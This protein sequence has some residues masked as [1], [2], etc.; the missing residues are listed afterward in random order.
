M[1]R[2]LG[3]TEV[4][5]RTRL[6]QKGGI[7][8]NLRKL[9]APS[10]SNY[11]K[12][13]PHLSHLALHDNLVEVLR[14]TVQRL[15]GQGLPLRVLE[16]GAGHGGFT[17]HALAMGCNVTVVDMSGPSVDE[18][19]RRFGTNPKFDSVY[20][21]D[22][23]LRDV[24]G[25]YTLLML[26]S[27]IHH[28]PDYISFLRD[29]SR[30]ISPGG[31][32]LTLQD[33]VWYPRHRASHEADRMS[34]FAWR[35]AQGN[36]IGGLKTRLRRIRG[37]LDET[38]PSDM[39]EYHVVRNG[40]DEQMVLSF[41]REEFSEATLIPY[42]SSHL[43]V[44]QHVGDRLGL[45]SAFGVVAH[46][47]DPGQADRELADR[48]LAGDRPA[49]QEDMLA[50]RDALVGDVKQQD[51][52]AVEVAD[53]ELIRRFVVVAEELNFTRAA[54]RL[55]LAQ[56]P[57]SA[58]I[59]KLERKLGVRL[60]ERTS[61][62]V[63]LT[64]AGAV[65]LEQGRITVE[66]AG[67]AIEQARRA[68]TQPRRLTVAVKPGTGTDLLKQIMQRC[69]EDPRMPQVHVLFGHPGG[70]AAAVRAGAADVAILRAPF[71]QRGLD[72]EL[73]LTE[74]RVAVLPAGHRLSGRPELRRAD[75]A[76]E[77][78][79]HWAGPPDPVA[80]AYWAGADTPGRAADPRD[81]ALPPGPEINDIS[82]LLDAVTL[83]HAVAYVPASV[84][85][86]HHA[87]DLAFI[88][89]SD[90]SPS[91]VMAAWP[92][93]SRSRAVAG[94]VRAAAEVAAAQA[95]QAAALA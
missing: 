61:R 69:A 21:P 72:A 74:P 5:S 57:L 45:N 55:G 62:R 77:P 83:G 94:F 79:P 29:A 9:H 54:A 50:A 16:I 64:P 3:K 84:A 63:T 91:Q 56:P 6:R 11:R 8:A 1:A 32:L 82:Q 88:P 30:R 28:I 87:A 80:A 52:A 81:G 12:G 59:G 34:Y 95:G 60:L 33:P 85:H 19:R 68:A 43:G 66:A 70:P 78:M 89:V 49:G 53:L 20:N 35:L 76:G 17:E 37:V 48:Q 67:A 44:A 36:A 46:G 15:S 41:A 39:V 24:D 31:A 51:I 58:A 42:W 14:G 40:V 65:L 25:D 10:S 7:V 86:Q 38:N 2:T 47:Y 73:L 22:G 18:L 26:V 90:L 71:D 27:V 23:T 4:S 93:I 75:L 13:S 92:D